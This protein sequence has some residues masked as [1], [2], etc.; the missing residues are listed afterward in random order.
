[1]EK[2]NGFI[3]ATDATNNRATP[4]TRPATL[5]IPSGQ[6]RRKG[7]EGCGVWKGS[8]LKLDRDLQ[9]AVDHLMYKTIERQSYRC[10]R[11]LFRF[12]VAVSSFPSSFFLR[13]AEEG[14]KA[15]Q[16]KLA[17]CSLARSFVFLPPPVVVVVDALPSR[18][19]PPLLSLLFPFSAASVWRKKG[20]SSV[21]QCSSILVLEPF[22][23]K[24]F[25][26]HN[27]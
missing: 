26:R 23:R 11:H 1:M 21:V 15:L 3:A 10:F 7:R 27:T 4:A 14:K 6:I 16:I 22:K 12:I 13:Y 17:P 20:I 8:F 9:W 19:I 25:D 24:L 5:L 2:R 18:V